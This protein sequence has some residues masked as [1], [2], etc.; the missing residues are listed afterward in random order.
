MKFYRKFFILKKA[1]TQKINRNKNEKIKTQYKSSS[2]T[3][4]TYANIVTGNE[5][6][7]VSEDY[8]N[9]KSASFKHFSTKQEKSKALIDIIEYK[10]FGLKV[11]QKRSSGLAN[12]Y[13]DYV[14]TIWNTRKSWKHKSKKRKQYFN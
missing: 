10:E 13:D 7:I 3:E 5:I 2:V 6:K 14:G 4:E 12:P 1:K 9:L 11:R 8:P